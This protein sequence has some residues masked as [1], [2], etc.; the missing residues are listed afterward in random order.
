MGISFYVLATRF[1]SRGYEPYITYI[2][3]ISTKS[4]LLDFVPIV[5][6]FANVFPTNLP[7]LS[8]KNEIELIIDLELCTDLFVWIL[9]LWLLSSLKS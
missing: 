4:P 5:W 9:T 1:I 2:Y 6:D 8:P 7:S 3:D